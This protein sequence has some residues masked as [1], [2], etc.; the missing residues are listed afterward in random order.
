MAK[1]SKMWRRLKPRVQRHAPG[2]KPGTLS[3]EPDA[4]P[5]T[6]R[7]M[8]YDKDRVVEQK[9]E[10][11]RELKEFLGKWPVVW[12]DVIGL[13]NEDKLRAIAE[14]FQMHPLA[15]EDVVHVHQ[16]AKVD[17]LRERTLHRGADSR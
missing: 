15:L 3:I 12:V 10:D 17:R 9:I 13:G 6:I 2:A 1:R 14:V 11:P 4:Q 5:T 16:R 7:V 8:A